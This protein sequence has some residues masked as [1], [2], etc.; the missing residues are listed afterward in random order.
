MSE[1]KP[2][3]ILRANPPR[4]CPVCKKPTYSQGG[5]H[6]QC[7]IVRA[8]LDWKLKNKVSK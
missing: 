4:L 8:D 7:A 2:T 6:P 5:E 3:P 1:K